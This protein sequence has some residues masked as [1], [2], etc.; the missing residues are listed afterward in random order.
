MGPTGTG[1]PATAVRSSPI[2][3]ALALLLL[4]AL[5]IGAAHAAEIEGIITEVRDGDTL[6]GSTLNRYTEK[7]SKVDPC[8]RVSTICVDARKKAHPAGTLPKEAGS[9]ASGTTTSA[10]PA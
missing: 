8:Y 5:N 6:S 4:A 3:Y 1:Y 7:F 9:Y 2:A 10:F